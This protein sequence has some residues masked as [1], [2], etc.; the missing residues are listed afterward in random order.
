MKKEGS[1]RFYKPKLGYIFCDM[2]GKIAAKHTLY[3]FFFSFIQ[4]LIDSCIIYKGTL[5]NSKSQISSTTANAL[6][7]AT[8]M[9]VKIVI[10]TENCDKIIMVI[11]T[12]LQI[13]QKGFGLHVNVPF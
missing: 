5:L 6:R 2:D 10:A 4:I 13:L 1:L 3:T 11:L 9:G 12:K 8:S 7:E